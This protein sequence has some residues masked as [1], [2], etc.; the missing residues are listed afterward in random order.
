[1]TRPATPGVPDAGDAQ[2]HRRLAT[3]LDI[4]RTY[5]PDREAMLAALRVALGLPRVLGDDGERR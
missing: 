4:E 2:S 1:M 5:A 3:P